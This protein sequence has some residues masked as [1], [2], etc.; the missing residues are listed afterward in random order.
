MKCGT[1]REKRGKANKG[2]EGGK[3]ERREERRR[4]VW[5]QRER[6]RGSRE[7]PEKREYDSGRGK[8]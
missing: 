2:G 1:G 8:G 6:L 7:A 4:R 5:I 3:G